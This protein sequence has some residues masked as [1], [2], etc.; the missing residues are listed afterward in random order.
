MAVGLPCV[1][2]AVG[3]IPEF[4]SDQENGLLVPTDDKLALQNGLTRLLADD[5]LRAKFS[6]QA[7]Q[8]V[9]E[10]YA[11]AGVAWV[12]PVRYLIVWMNT[13]SKGDLT[14]S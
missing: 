13:P 5:A 9:V 12:V 7:R 6:A 11:I 14:G 10:K 4:I 8:R 3:A 2:T 1:A